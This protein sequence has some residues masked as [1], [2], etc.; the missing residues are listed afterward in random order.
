MDKKEISIFLSLIFIIVILSSLISAS[1]ISERT[2]I[3]SYCSG[4]SSKLVDVR[5]NAGQSNYG[6]GLSAVCCDGVW[7]I[8]VTGSNYE[9]SCNGKEGLQEGGW[10][11][12]D[13]ASTCTDT[14][15]GINLGTYGTVKA[16]RGPGIVD[17]YYDECKSDY[18]LM[19]AFCKLG[20]DGYYYASTGHYTCQYGCENGACKSAQASSEND[21][22]IVEETTTTTAVN[23][24]TPAK[25]KKQIKLAKAKEKVRLAKLARQNLINSKLN[26]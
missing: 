3:N 8:N 22:K 9:S 23:K 2:C 25:E 12:C 18:T 15:G 7:W 1:P 5:N 17:D 10:Y 13:Q 6:Y 16:I 21:I 14:D 26:K 19:E 11:R 4:I 24:M 20:S